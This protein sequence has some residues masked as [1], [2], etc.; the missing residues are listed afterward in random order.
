M[1]YCTVSAQRVGRRS[2]LFRVLKWIIAVAIIIDVALAVRGYDSVSLRAWFRASPFNRIHKT[3]TKD[4]V[5][6][7]VGRPEAIEP[8]LDY[9]TWAYYPRKPASSNREYDGSQASENVIVKF[10]VDGRVSRTTP[11]MPERKKGQI[12]KPGMAQKQVLRCDGKPDWVREAY[13]EKWV[14]PHWNGSEHQVLFDRKGRVA[15]TIAHY[16]ILSRPGTSSS[17]GRAHD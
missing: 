13:A 14:Y 6:A 9:A 7:I 2:R 17:G 5:E 12:I 15:W 10:G 4:Q 11:P 3:M 16:Q 8:N 1:S